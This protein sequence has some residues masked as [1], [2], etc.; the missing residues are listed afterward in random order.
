MITLIGKEKYTIKGKVSTDRRLYKKIVVQSHNETDKCFALC[1]RKAVLQ[2]H[3]RQN[4]ASY[5]RIR[6]IA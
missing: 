4:K 1:T 6:R 2:K 3:N 5:K